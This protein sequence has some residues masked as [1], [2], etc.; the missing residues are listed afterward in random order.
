MGRTSAS[1]Q[2]YAHL[3][4]LLTGDAIAFLD[5]N[6]RPTSVWKMKNAELRKTSQ[7]DAPTESRLFLT[8]Y[9]L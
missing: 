8:I 7:A 9:D 2:I 4:G 6:G 1:P 3:Q 5:A